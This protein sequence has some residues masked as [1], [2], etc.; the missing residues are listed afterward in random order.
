MACLEKPLKFPSAGYELSAYIHIHSPDTG[1]AALML[2]GFTGNKVESNRLFVDIARAL[3]RS[4]LL[5]FRFDYRGHGDSPLDFEEFR[6]EYAL[7]DAE[8]A[9]RYLLDNYRPVKTVLIGL[10]MGGHIAV[11][12]AVAYSDV[13][14]GIV[15]LSPALR[16]S[17]PG[18]DLRLFAQRVGDYY[19]FGPF[20]MRAD[21]LENMVKYNA[22][23][24]ADKVRIPVLIIH[25]EDDQIIS[26]TQSREFYEKLA[27]RDK[28]LVLLDHGGHVFSTY[29][30]KM[31]VITE[32]SSW[33][34][35]K[36]GGS[37]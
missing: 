5:V 12:L 37:K 25:A 18:K 7:E 8:N 29:V 28:K 36:L 13:L 24:L 32:I 16:F 35:E 27:T 19:V 11:R 15:L 20:R 22:I 14:S 1:K 34:I 31:K 23:E 9:L 3:C 10:S 33:V 2:H 17:E 30:S 26:Y 4:G 6:F 21:A